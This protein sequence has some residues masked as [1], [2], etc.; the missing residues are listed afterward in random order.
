MATTRGVLYI[1][2]GEQYRKEARQSLATLRRVSPN[3]VCAV[4]TDR[5]WTEIP[6]P[7]IVV[8]RPLDA[9]F[10]SKPRQMYDASP[11]EETL[12]LDTDTIV[13]R[14]VEPLF[15]LLRWYDVGVKFAGPQLNEPDGLLYHTQTSSNLILFRKCETVAHTFALWREEFDRASAAVAE[16]GDRRG[17]ADQRYF[18]IAIARSKAR[19]VHLDDYVL[20]NLGESMITYSPPI[21]V[22]GRLPEM[23]Q[24]ARRL[25]AGWDPVND[26][27]PR[28]W[29]PDVRGLLPLRIRRAD[30]LLFLAYGVRRAFNRLRGLMG[31]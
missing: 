10:G 1:A 17:L 28:F 4:L 22:H 30:P 11:F 7:D 5:P 3:V 25:V 9:S 12:Y 29:L 14:D 27:E 24:I 16:V 21:V 6:A 31:R 8:L 2:F 18:A 15:G 20:F 13:V 19:P 26:W 23:D